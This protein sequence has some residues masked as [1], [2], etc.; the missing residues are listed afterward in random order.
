MTN[1]PEIEKLLP[2]Y[3]KGLLEPE[4]AQRVDAYLEEHPEMRMQLGLI[5]EENDAIAQQHA[6]LGAPVPGGLDRLLSDIDALEA[7]E[8]PL[9]HS[10]GASTIGRMVQKFKDLLAS[11]ASPGVR[12]AAMAAA[13]VIVAQGVVIGGLM[14]DG[15]AP[16]DVSSKFTTA[17]GPQ[18]ATTTN[19]AVFLVAF[20]K[21]ARMNDVAQLLKLQSAKII[22]GPKA[23]GFFEIM[24]PVN[25]L[26][27][28]GADGVLKSLQAQ[29]NLVQFISINQ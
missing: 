17:S 20:Q 28:G 16:T 19:G 7:T 27:E 6:A 25:K 8:A 15:T 26:P 4:E 22:A 29:T 3:A 21:D 24:V 13:L 10:I 11:F 23:G 5:A 1:N 2:W 12:F 9:A 18:Q 14:R